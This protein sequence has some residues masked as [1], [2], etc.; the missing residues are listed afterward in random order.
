[1]AAHLLLT[2]QFSNEIIAEKKNVVYVTNKDGQV[3]IPMVVR[4]KL[5]KP[6]VLPDIGELAQRAGSHALEQ[7]LGRL[8][9][10]KGKGLNLPFLS[11]D[12]GGAPS[13]GGNAKPASNPL[14]QLKGLFH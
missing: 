3:D 9:G 6:A 2:R 4:G 12:G 13:S 14:D 11:D 10:K 8:L 7:N 5:P 1:M